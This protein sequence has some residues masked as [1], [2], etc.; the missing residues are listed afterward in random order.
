MPSFND[1]YGPIVSRYAVA[2]AVRS[3]LQLWLPSQLAEIE[4]QEGL[5]AH[6]LPLPPDSDASYKI[7]L[8]FTLDVP[9][10]IVP[11]LLIVAQPF[12]EPER[13]PVIDQPFEIQIG[14]VIV[15]TDEDEA[16]MF[17]DLYGAAVMSAIGQHGSLGTWSNGDP[18][19][20]ES[21]L[22]GFPETMYMAPDS[23]LSR[24]LVRSTVT[25]E[26]LISNVFDP[27][28]GPRSV[29]SNPYVD[30]GNWPTVQSTNV[31]F[32]DESLT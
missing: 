24:R 4:R 7:V 17:A 16:I 26:S 30:P 11:C 18:V 13:M 31:T 3:Q 32:E 22:R 8:D 12:G 28:Q 9:Q 10:Q 1:I 15:G 29:P 5:A 19:A 14:S 20:T 2:N 23:P 21:A 27:R 6:T 25:F